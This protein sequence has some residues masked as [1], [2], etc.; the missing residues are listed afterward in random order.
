MPISHRNPTALVGPIRRLLV[1]DP[2]PLTRWSLSSYLNRWFDVTALATVD[3]AGRVLHERDFD[4]LVVS[5]QFGETTLCALERD[6]RANNRQLAII[7]MVTDL[8]SATAIHHDALLL[9]KPF[10]LSHL[11]ELLG[12]QQAEIA[13]PLPDHRRPVARDNGRGR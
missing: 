2:D 4:A 12:I 5:D 8:D 1:V 3:A 6:G 11:A 7:E 9:E 10:K 13:A